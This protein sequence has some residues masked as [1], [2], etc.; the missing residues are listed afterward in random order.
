MTAASI[1]PLPATAQHSRNGR[2]VRGIGGWR[3]GN[4]ICARR[5]VPTAGAR[6]MDAALFVGVD[7]NDTRLATRSRQRPTRTGGAISPSVP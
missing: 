2:A 7:G 4:T 3:F 5:R 1:E 6:L